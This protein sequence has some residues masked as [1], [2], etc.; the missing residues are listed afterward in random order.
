M[1]TDLAAF[2]AVSAVVIVT[3][4]QDTALT[5]KNS[6][7]GGRGGGV[8]TA[9]G[10]S[11][12]QAIWAL[13]TSLGLATLLV[14]SEALFSIVK[15]AGAVYLIALGVHALVHAL[16]RRDS[17]AVSGGSSARR[18]PPRVALR[19]GA[20][21]NL[22]NVK[23]AVFFTSLLPQFA[24]AGSFGGLLVLGVLFSTMTLVWLSAYAFVVAKAGDVLRRSAVRRAL[25][26]ATGA[27]LVALGLRLATTRA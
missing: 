3:P 26:A 19:Q 13:A 10:V 7:A 12:G 14:A 27:V 17:S 1:I 5:I 15:L 24:H 8:F 18:L 25:D 21:S 23:M 6:L 20:I 4:G 22:G 11:I 2:L 16:R 9:V